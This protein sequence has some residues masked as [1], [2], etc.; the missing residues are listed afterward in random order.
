MAARSKLPTGEQHRALI[1]RDAELA[2]LRETLDHA[3]RGTGGIVL[4]EGEAGIG[5]TRLLAEALALAVERGFTVL[6][7]AADEVASDRPFGALVEALALDGAP[8]D[9]ER[10]ALGRLIAVGVSA[11]GSPPGG[12]AADLGYHIIESIVGVVE[13]IASQTPLF[14]SIED[15]HWADPLTLRAL[16]S[17]WRVL[18]RLPVVVVATMRPFPRSTDLDGA[19]TDL[20][21]GRAR[22]IAL[23]P[24]GDDAVGDL[25]C[26]VTG[27]VPGPRLTRQLA[28]AGGNPLFIVELVAAASAGGP[29]TATDDPPA[30]KPELRR[31]I[32]RRVR[33]LPRPTV[34][35]LKVAAVLGRRFGLSQLSAVMER[36]PVELFPV[37]ED[38]LASGVLGEEEGELVFRHELI[39]DAVY[40]DLT[41]ALRRGLHRQAART[42]AA[43]GAPRTSVADHLLAG[44]TPG[45]QEA[46]AWLAQ[47][48][49]AAAAHSP[50]TA[51]RLLEAAV[52]LSAD[53]ADHADPANPAGAAADALSVELAPLLI[54]AG[55]A[56]EAERLSRQI[57]ARTHD[58]AVVGGLRRALGEVL[59]T[60]GWLEPA[61]GE[62]E[63]AA[64][65]EQLDATQRCGASALAANLRLFL[66]EPQVAAHQAS[67]ALAEG[68]ALGDDFSV[69][70]GQ[71]TLA[72]AADAD[73]R[74]GDAVALAGLAVRTARHS[75]QA[76]VGHLH[77]HLALG[78]VLLDADRLD[79]AEEA[80]QEGRLL[81]ERRGTVSWLPVYHCALAM[82][83]ILSGAW[84]DA[85]AEVEVGMNLADEIGTRL[86]VPFLHGMAAWA[87]VQRGELAH[88]QSRMDAAVS[89]FVVTLSKAWQAD[90]SGSFHS[91][92]ARWPLEWGLW[93]NGLLH[94]ARGDDAQALSAME[95][96]W[97]LAAPLRFFLGY[98]LFAP[99]LIRLA[100][101]AGNRRLAASVAG[102]VAEGA[103]RSGVA[104]ARAAARR[105]H[106]L[107]ADDVDRLVEAADAYRATPQVLERAFTTEEAGA[108]LARVGRDTEAVAY[109]EEALA[110]F[111]EARATRVVARIEASLRSLGIRHR[112][113]IAPRPVDG[114]EALTPTELRVAR[115]A[116]EGLTNRQIG[117]QLF[118]SRRTIETHLAHAFRK[119]GFTTRTQLAA[120]V[121][122]RRAG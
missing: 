24:L 70:L 82:R 20:S 33:S 78:F 49:R 119:L 77:P 76:R 39:R 69:C 31:T 30:G 92:G 46:V 51:V 66:G 120:E 7:G 38:A 21:S 55:R 45:D 10:A 89:E 111:E 16:R 113:S 4:V 98:R 84:D 67:L 122:R 43:A 52:S 40:A 86:Y 105:C 47:A 112:R 27:A 48:G 63:A 11:A 5:K 102:E 17:L 28:A 94:E 14:L 114:W 68:E 58:L 91:A 72:L 35:A 117:E 104:S 19:L 1:G 61:V 50:Q 59:W 93:I 3:S 53:P 107:V 18:V 99:D 101:R 83:R 90:A 8:P 100:L 15:L 79:D 121:A 74:V 29:E 103:R 37:L 60:L 75:T 57:L 97:S 118:V 73:G 23:G 44:A 80:L 115:L 106:A 26:S 56:D 110:L 25:A 88:A 81:A 36:S 108:A 22:C 96:A 34:D 95:D 42:L 116:A 65:V 12:A 64:A 85:M 109:L 13:Q 32:L 9:S 62:L 54:Q 2:V 6:S 87:A 41:L 71:Q